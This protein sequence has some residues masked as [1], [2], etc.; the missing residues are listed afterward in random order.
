MPGGYRVASDNSNVTFDSFSEYKRYLVA[1]IGR[2]QLADLH[3]ESKV[4]DVVI[5]YCDKWQ[6]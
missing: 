4:K 3:K 1:S 2:E 5:V 6:A